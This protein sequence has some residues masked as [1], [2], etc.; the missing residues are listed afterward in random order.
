MFRIRRLAC[1]TL[2]LATSLSVTGCAVP[3]R[4]GVDY[5]EHARPVYFDDVSQV[6]ATPAPVR[7]QIRDGNALW[8]KLCGGPPS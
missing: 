2:L 7:R 5:C 1:T 8:H 3:A 4:V 6:D